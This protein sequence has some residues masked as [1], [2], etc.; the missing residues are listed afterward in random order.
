MPAMTRQKIV[1]FSR[2]CARTA[3]KLAAGLG[4]EVPTQ[5]LECYHIRIFLFLSK[6]FLN[7]NGAEVPSQVLLLK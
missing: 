5:V 7:T 3:P 4:A 1:N 6:L 2:S